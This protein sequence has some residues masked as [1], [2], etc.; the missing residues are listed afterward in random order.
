V[1]DRADVIR[2]ADVDPDYTQRP[3]PARTVEA[4]R[5]LGR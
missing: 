2:Q 5:S 1:V 4:L 3:E